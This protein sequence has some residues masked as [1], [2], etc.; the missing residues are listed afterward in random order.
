MSA[1]TGAAL[2]QLA[3]L[4]GDYTRTG[5]AM[6]TKADQLGAKIREAVDHFNSTMDGLLS[7]T[8]QLTGQIETDMTSLTSTAAGVEWTGN[9]RGRFD[10]DIT[11]FGSAVRKGTEAMRQDVTELK[12]EVGTKFNPSLEAF[13][14]A[15]GTRVDT[16]N[17]GTVETSQAVARQRDLLDTAANTGWGA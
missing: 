13:G 10:G 2:E 5:Q 12:S 11:A 7:Q 16:V 4:S 14:Q 3:E 1:M 8:T 9:N 15:L 17:T 6:L